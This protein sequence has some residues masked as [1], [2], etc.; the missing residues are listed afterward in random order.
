[1]VWLE[2]D[3]LAKDLLSYLPH[4]YATYPLTITYDSDK[5]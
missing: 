1:M 4:S 2:T 5:L 3:L